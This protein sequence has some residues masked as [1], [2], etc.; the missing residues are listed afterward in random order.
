MIDSRTTLII[1]IG[2]AVIAIVTITSC[3]RRSDTQRP[4]GTS[5]TQGTPSPSERLRALAAERDDYSVL[6]GVPLSSPVKW[7]TVTKIDNDTLSVDGCG[8]LPLSDVRAFIVAYPNGQ[9]LDCNAGGLALPEGISGLSP[10]ADADRDTLELADL[11]LGKQYVKVKYGSST[12]RPRDPNYY[13]T[14]VTNISNERIKVYRFA[15]YTKTSSGW[16]LFTVTNK[17]YSAEEFREWYGLRT[18]EWILPG[19][20][21]NDPNNYGSRP[22]LWA[23]YCESESGKRFIA[24]SV[25]Q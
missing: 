21:V 6:V 17:F 19:E 13:S 5:Q 4:R 3:A 16:T 14:I 18:N 22:V 7:A 25:L 1:A 9:L 2:L 15:G 23:Y 20:S 8:S 11:E 10:S 12:S 24:G